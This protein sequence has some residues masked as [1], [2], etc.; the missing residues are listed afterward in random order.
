ML[1]EKMFGSVYGKIWLVIVLIAILTL[2]VYL[3]LRKEKVEELTI[4]ESK[5][6]NKEEIVVE[7]TTETQSVAKEQQNESVDYGNFIIVESE[8]GFFR[9]RK[10]DNERT[11]RKFSTRVEAENYIE[12]RNLSND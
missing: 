2:I 7:E 11:I 10:K 12:K 4:E 3:L 9:V 8:D 1:L 6:K 5:E